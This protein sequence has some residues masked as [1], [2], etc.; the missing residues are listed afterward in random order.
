MM[1]IPVDDKVADREFVWLWLQTPVVR[2]FIQNNAKGTSPTMKKISQGT[3]LNIPFPS[4]LK[5]SDQMQMVR[6]LKTVKARIERSKQ[7][8][9][10]S[11]SEVDAI[12]PSII[13]MAFRGEL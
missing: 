5:L 8:Q 10:R 11:A 7:L 3:V 12:L 9:K 13:D 2:E 6:E 4:G 1:R